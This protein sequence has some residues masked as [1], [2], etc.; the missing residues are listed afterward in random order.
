MKDRNI[1]FLIALI[2]GLLLMILF[3]ALNSVSDGGLVKRI[4]ILLG[5]SLPS[6]FIQ[7]LS[8]V[9]FIYGM[10]EIIRMSNEVTNEARALRMH[11]LPEKEQFVLSSDEVQQLKL[12]MIEVEKR[13]VFLLTDLIKKA[14]TKFR[15]NKSTS[16]AMEVVTN[17]SSVNL[18]RA[19]SEQ[20][21]IRYIVW[22][23]PSVGFVGTVIGIASSLSMANDITSSDGLDRITAALGIAFDTTLVALVLSLFVMYFYH[24]LQ[25]RVEA[26]HANIESYVIENLVN[27]IY[28]RENVR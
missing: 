24:R 9:L 27:R 17:F 16:E 26:L 1:N 4:L 6:G 14:C 10:L 5:G 18:R 2:A 23:I 15:S 20:S 22:A 12:K 19:E 21:M 13:E 28:H 8:Y 11:L 25:E 3:V 7:A